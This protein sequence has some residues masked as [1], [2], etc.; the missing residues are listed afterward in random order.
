MSA[1]IYPTTQTRLA[2]ELN[3]LVSQMQDVHARA[4]K[5]KLIL[6]QIAIGGDY[7]SLATELGYTTAADAEAAYNLL[8]SALADDINGSFYTQMISRMG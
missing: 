1:H 3:T 8:G 7:A 4:E 6:D 2:G 5:L